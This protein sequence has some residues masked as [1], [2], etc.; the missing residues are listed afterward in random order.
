M[1]PSRK[2]IAVVIPKYGLTGGAEGYAAEL[3]SRLANEE[4]FEIHVLANKWHNS[5]SLV[6]FHKIPIISFPRF[7]T[8]V[9]FAYFVSKKISKMPFDLIHTHDRIFTADLFSM[10]GIPHEIWVKEVRKKRMGLFDYCTA[11]VEKKLVYSGKCQK[12]LA[13]SNLVKE[14]FLDAYDIQPSNK[15][16]IIYPGIDMQR[17]QKLERKECRQ[18]IRSRL[19][20]D[21]A[22]IVILFVSMNF[23]HKGLDRL[24]TFL[25]NLKSQKGLNRI[26]LLIVGKDH[27]KNFKKLAQSLGIQELVIFLGMQRKEEL[28]K[29]ILAS[30][31][32]SLLSIFD[33]FGIAV[34]EAMAASLPVII[35]GNMGVKELISQGINGFFLEDPSSPDEFMEKV[36]YLLEEKVRAKIGKEAMKT[37]AMFTWDLAAQKTKK[38]YMDFFKER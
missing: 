19:G 23:L 14:K 17:F 2:K 38:I 7:L 32:F 1:P 12:F 15:V 5:S 34:L 16:Q 29:I 20:I 25:A 10:H 3:T 6:T 28:D 26:K 37:A 13:V 30:D 24:M 8:T 4:K 27:E 35:S 18:E 11:Y 33:T 9:S 21:P 31:I 22:D 36:S